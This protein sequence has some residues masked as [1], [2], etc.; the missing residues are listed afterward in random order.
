MWLVSNNNQ[1]YSRGEWKQ[2]HEWGGGCLLF[3]AKTWVLSIRFREDQHYEKSSITEAGQCHLDLLGAKP[4]ISNFIIRVC[5]HL[6][7]SSVWQRKVGMRWQ[8]Y[9]IPAVATGILP[10]DSPANVWSFL[11]LSGFRGCRPGSGCTASRKNPITCYGHL[12]SV[13]SG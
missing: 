9:W 7:L 6:Q 4:I 11:T 1:G 8:E 5:E 13:N 12:A 2:R 3:T 10:L